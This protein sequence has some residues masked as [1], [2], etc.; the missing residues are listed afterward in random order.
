ISFDPDDLQITL[1]IRELA[2][3]TEKFPVL[4]GQ[5]AE[6]QVGEDV[7]QQNQPAETVLLEHASGLARA[8]GVRSQMHV[9]K[10]QRIV[11][12]RIHTLILA[13]ECYGM[14]KV[15]EQSGTHVPTKVTPAPRRPRDQ[16]TLS[17]IDRLFRYGRDI[18]F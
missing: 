3:V 12:G 18:L 6:I 10:D 17:E 14:M 9:G 7:A 4:F 2:D 16:S 13:R 1:R 11:D 15:S 5:P 8:A